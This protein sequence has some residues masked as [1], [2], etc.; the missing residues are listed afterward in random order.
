MIKCDY[1]GKTQEDVKRIITGG[2][3]AAICGECVLMCMEI[4]LQEV[5]MDYKEI[6]FQK[7]EN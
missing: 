4:L 1:C 5:S 2:A 3:G 7:D 6:K